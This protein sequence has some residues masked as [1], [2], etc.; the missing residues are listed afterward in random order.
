VLVPWKAKMDLTS[1]ALALAR[2]AELNKMA[3]D[4]YSPRSVRYHSRRFDFVRKVKPTQTP[5]SFATHI[6]IEGGLDEE[7]KDVFDSVG[8]FDNLAKEKLLLQAVEEF[9]SNL[10]PIKFEARK[11]SHNHFERGRM[12]KT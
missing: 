2:T 1:S 8:Y 9:L 5:L 4:F 6:R 10:N 12:R 11:C 3:K 7:E